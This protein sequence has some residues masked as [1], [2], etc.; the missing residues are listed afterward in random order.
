[1]PTEKVICTQLRKD[2]TGFKP[3][4]MDCK[5]K[6]S[7]YLIHYINYINDPLMLKGATKIIYKLVIQF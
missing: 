1:M 3:T 2:T 5:R 7:Q 4:K 6:L